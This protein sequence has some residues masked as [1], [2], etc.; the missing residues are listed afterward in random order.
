MHN[1]SERRRE[2]IV[3]KVLIA[4]KAERGWFLCLLFL[5]VFTSFGK[6]YFHEN[7]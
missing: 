2:E 5:E 1:F 7:A 3:F 6:Y 4:A